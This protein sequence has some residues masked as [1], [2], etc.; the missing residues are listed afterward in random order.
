MLFQKLNAH[1]Y[2]LFCIKFRSDFVAMNDLG[3]PFQVKSAL[4]IGMDAV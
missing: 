2:T 4:S 3:I 1:S